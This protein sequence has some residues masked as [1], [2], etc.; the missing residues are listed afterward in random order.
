[1]K[2]LFEFDRQFGSRQIVGIDEAGRGPL[3]G[4]VVAAAAVLPENGT[5][6]ALGDSKKLTEAERELAYAEITAQAVAYHVEVIPAEEIDQ[7]NIL[8]ATKKAMVACG[9]AV[10]DATALVLVDGNQRIDIEHEQQTIIKGD[11]KSAAIAA[12]SILAK[13]TR[14]RLMVEYD[15]EFPQYGFAKHKGY[16]TAFHREQIKLHGACAIH[17]RTFLRKLEVEMAQVSLF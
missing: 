17:R 5:F 11:D 16:G 6:S 12:A 10:A 1:M 13:V 3:A 15:A 2:K 4:P 8:N 9:K 7:I 14:D